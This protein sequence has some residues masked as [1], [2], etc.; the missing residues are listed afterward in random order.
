MFVCVCV[1]GCER[2]SERECVSG[3]CGV[4]M[5]VCVRLLVY[6]CQCL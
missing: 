1:R 2:A 5:G 4:C 6:G 3:V